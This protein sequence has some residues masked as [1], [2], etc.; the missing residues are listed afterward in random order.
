MN[1]KE[2]KIEE[3]MKKVIDEVEVTP[4]QDEDKEFEKYCKLYEEK[5]GKNTYIAEPSGT[6]KQTIDAIKTCLEKEED[7]LDELLY[8]NFNDD[9]K[10]NVLY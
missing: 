1:E 5:F 8:P 3:Y 9:M 10:N 7:I 2:N 4:L 6:K